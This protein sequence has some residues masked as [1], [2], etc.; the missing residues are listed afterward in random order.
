MEYGG[1]A[2]GGGDSSGLL[3]RD[4]EVGA[5]RAAAE[6]AARRDGRLVVV[7]ADGGLGKTR[8]LDVAAGAAE[9]AGA[10]VLRARGTELERGFPFG[11][12]IQLL[13]RELECAERRGLLSGIASLAAPLL[14]RDG[15]PAEGGAVDAIVHGLSWLGTGLTKERPPALI[16]DDA[17]WADEPSLRLLAHLAHRVA[18]LRLLLVVGARPNEP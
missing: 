9:E 8:L 11:V 12:A 2:M 17:H 13:R 14:E 1:A 15:R 6:D 18:D 7:A 3:E 5:I 10:H 4:R 16:A